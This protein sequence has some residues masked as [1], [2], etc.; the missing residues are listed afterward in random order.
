[1]RHRIRE[2]TS[3]T[4]HVEA[5]SN[6]QLQKTMFI[7]ED[8][9]ATPQFVDIPNAWGTVKIQARGAGYAIAQLS[10][11]YNV[12]VN[13]FVTQPPVRSFSLVPRLSFSGRNNSHITYDICSSWVNQRES[14]TSGMAVLDVAVPTGYHMQQQVLDEYILSRRVR[15]LRR[16]KFLDHKVVFYFDALDADPTCVKFTFERWYPVANM[17][18]YLPIRVYDYYAPERFNETV[19]ES[20]E[21]YVLDICQVC[22]SYQCTYCPTYNRAG[23]P[24]PVALLSIAIALLSVLFSAFYHR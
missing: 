4:L 16:A 9:L 7:T 3:L 17:T 15:S 5:T 24:S 19:V 22:G 12:D 6:P 2:V 10:L 13:R 14:N 18:R 20:F 11:Q 23:T 8:N 21:L 1:M